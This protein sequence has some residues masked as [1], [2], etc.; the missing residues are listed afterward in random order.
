[1]VFLSDTTD[2][3]VQNTCSILSSTANEHLAGS[4]ILML[5]EDAYLV[6]VYSC[7]KLKSLFHLMTNF[8]TLNSFPYVKH[9][10]S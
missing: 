9:A 4:Q 3:T 2:I 8:Q 6:P 7:D 10:I 5:S 1:M